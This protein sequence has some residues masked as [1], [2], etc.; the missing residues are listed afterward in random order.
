MYATGP[1]YDVQ[2][3]EPLLNENK[4]SY[5]LQNLAKEY[6]DEGKTSDVMLQWA[7]RAFGPNP[8]S[9]MHLIPPSLVGGIRCML[10]M[11]LGP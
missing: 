4:Q 11:G 6:L 3:A 7:E 10:L 1:F 2:V 5:A 8:M 9:N